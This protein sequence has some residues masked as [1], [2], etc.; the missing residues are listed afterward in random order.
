MRNFPAEK[1]SLAPRVRYLK[2][3][4]NISLYE[5]D[6]LEAVVFIRRDF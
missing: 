5:Y 3:D 2:N 6:R 1:W 4:S